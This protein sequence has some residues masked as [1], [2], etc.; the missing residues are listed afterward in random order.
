M[1]KDKKKIDPP[2]ASRLELK[3]LIRAVIGLI[4]FILGFNF[5]RSV[6]FR[7]YPLFGVPYLAEVLISLVAGLFGFFT[8]PGWTKKAYVYVEHLITDTIAD[9]ISN[10]IQ[11]QQKKSAV[12]KK[13]KEKQ[14]KRKKRKGPPAIL[15]DTSVL[16]DGRIIN[17]A[18]NGFLDGTYIIPKNVLKELQLLADNPDKLKRQKGRRGLDMVRELKKYVKTAFPFVKTTERDVDTFLVTFA[19]YQ[20]MKL[21]TLDFNLI[22]VAEA[23]GVKVLNINKLAEGLKVPLIPGE[24]IEIEIVQPGKEKLQGLGYLLDGTMIVVENAKDLVGKKVKARV[25]KVI[26]SVAGK[27]VFCDLIDMNVH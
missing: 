9:S 8:F 22:K 27:M 1:E 23:Q 24:E 4:F 15:V 17:I 6:F 21:V 26:Q 20:K 14:E 11:E 19:K 10:F 18:K 25:V 7:E 12:A 2:R 3:L 5:S 13:E 16:I